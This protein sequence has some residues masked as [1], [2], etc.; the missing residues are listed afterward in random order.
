LDRVAYR[1]DEWF[2]A[3]AHEASLLPVQDEPLMRWAKQAAADGDTWTGL[4]R[5]AHREPAYVQSV[6]DE[7]TERGPMLASE[8]SDPRPRQ[9]EWWDGRSVGRLALDWLFRIGEVGIRRVGNFEKEWDRLDRIV[10]AEVQARPT[11]DRDEAQKEL[12]VR[13]AQA[14]GVGTLGCLVDYYRLPKKPARGQIAE[15]VEDGRLQEVEVE[16]WAQPGYV[17]P[18]VSIPRRID[19]AAVVS[20][21]DPVVW[22]RPR[23]DLLFGFEY[24]IEIYVPK[25]KRQYGYYVLPFL[26][27]DRLV[28]R[29]DV[30]TDRDAGVLRVHAAFAEAHSHPD[31][32]AEPMVAALHRLA[33][34]VGVGEV[35]YGRRGDL[36][37]TLA[38]A[39]G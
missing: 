17:A 19:A 26:L 32:I 7:V 3:W 37:A 24:R 8:L 11:P 22:N 18:D 23:A 36:I 12:L 39:D 31:E 4:A 25:D 1:D 20:P 29:V 9:G 5:L 33:E 14:L 13:S 16:A 10:P 27:G 34:F 28:A 30:K 35:T 38:Q 6:L 2:E 21:F 15:L